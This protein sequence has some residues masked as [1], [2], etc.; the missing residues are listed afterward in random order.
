MRAGPR[1]TEPGAEGPMGR[2]IQPAAAPGADPHVLTPAGPP[3]SPLSKSGFPHEAVSDPVRQDPAKKELPF[4]CQHWTLPT[5]FQI[6]N[7][8]INL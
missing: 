1:N 2:P 6:A 5:D 4:P 3:M 8:R 7:G